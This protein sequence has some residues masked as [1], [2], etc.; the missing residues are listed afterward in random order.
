EFDVTT[1]PADFSEILTEVF[2]S[3]SFTFHGITGKAVNADGTSN[4]SWSDDGFVNK[5]AVKYVVKS[6][7]AQ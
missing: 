7:N 1:S 4:I 3:D 6:A 5:E 2:T